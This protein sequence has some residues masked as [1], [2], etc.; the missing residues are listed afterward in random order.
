MN[1]STNPIKL[2][3]VYARVSTSNQENEGTIETQ[4]S[5]VNEFANK[6]GYTIVQKYIDNGWS[7]DVIARPALDNMRE[8]AKK[9]IW[10]AVLIQTG[11]LV[12]IHTKNW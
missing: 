10:E 8:D 5:A 7:G 4:L 1:E 11:L 6:N 12:G 9:K 2:I 3:A